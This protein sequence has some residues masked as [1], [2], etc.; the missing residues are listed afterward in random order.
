M[1]RADL[2]DQQRQQL[3]VM[4]PAG[5]TEVVRDPAIQQPLGVLLV[6]EQ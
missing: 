3:A 5:Q 2:V 6:V 1:Q 4:R